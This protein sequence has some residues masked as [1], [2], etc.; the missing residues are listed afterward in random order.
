MGYKSFPIRS[1]QQAYPAQ[2]TLL[3][4]TKRER[5]EG[6]TYK[7]TVTPAR[8]LEAV[9][10]ADAPVATAGEVGEALGCTGQAARKKL[11]QL[12]EEGE[13]ERMEV[14]A[15]AVVWWIPDS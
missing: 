8:V 11:N 2:A 9:R 14:G 5:T 13:I 7:E 6:G 12:H 3:D 1:W 15:R 4:M 10:S